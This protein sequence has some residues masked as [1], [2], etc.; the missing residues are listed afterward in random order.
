[1]KFQMIKHHVAR[2][3]VVASAALA[4]AIG[5]ST[6]CAQSQGQSVLQQRQERG[7]G[8][9]QLDTQQRIDRRVQSMTQDLQLSADQ[10]ARIRTILTNESTQMQALRQKNGFQGPQRGGERPDGQRPD[11]ARGDRA[12]AGFGGRRQLPPEVKALRDQTEKQIDAVLNSSQRAKYQQLREQREK[13]HQ[14]HDGQ[15]GQRAS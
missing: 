6:A 12:G 3:G 14:Q 1:M 8:R 13:E 9:G 15:P 5:A 2:S 7:E 10:Q 11:S 4:L